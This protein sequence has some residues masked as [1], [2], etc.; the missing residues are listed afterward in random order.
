M[1]LKMEA[2]YSF[3]TLLPFYQILIQ[4]HTITL[5][6]QAAFERQIYYPA[7]RLQDI[8]T[9]KIRTMNEAMKLDNLNLAK[10]FVLGYSMIYNPVPGGITVP[11]YFWRM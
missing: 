10:S 8:F 1:N 7:N 9:L 6:F 3:E 5:K 4:Y 2:V 11:P